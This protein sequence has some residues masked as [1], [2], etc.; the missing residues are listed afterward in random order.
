M[1][2]KQLFCTENF[3]PSPPT[4]PS[5]SMKKNSKSAHEQCSRCS[6]LRGSLEEGELLLNIQADFCCPIGGIVIFVPDGASP[7]G[8]LQ[9]L[10][11][12]H[13]FPGVPGRSH[14]RIKYFTLEGNIEG[15]DAVTMSFDKAQLAIT[16][17][18]VFPGSIS[19]TQQ[20]LEA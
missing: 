1:A 17:G 10:H 20:L 2:G 18:V 3:T 16:A 9:V 5:V 4:I 12:V 14:D 19:R 6:K 8:V 15:F 13:L 7:T 11:G